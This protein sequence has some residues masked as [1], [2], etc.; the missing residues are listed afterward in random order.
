MEA[1]AI[2]VALTHIYWVQ[3]LDNIGLTTKD[4]D[5]LILFLVF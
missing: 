3:F 1:D 5:W 2:H 4:P